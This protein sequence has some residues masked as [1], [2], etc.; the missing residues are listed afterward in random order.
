MK[1]P[2]PTTAKFHNCTGARAPWD[3]VDR[4]SHSII[5]HKTRTEVKGS[6]R[7][8]EEHAHSTAGAPETFSA[9]RNRDPQ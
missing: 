6:V 1:T 4:V 7:D 2:G 9:R 8:G 5:N 3:K